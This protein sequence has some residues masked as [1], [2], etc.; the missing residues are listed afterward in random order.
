VERWSQGALQIFGYTEAEVRNESAD[1]IF[2]EEDRK[3]GAPEQEMETAKTTGR[4]ADERWHKRK[5][6]SLFFASGVMRP[7]QSSELTGYVK[8][9]RDT[10]KQQLF[11]E[12]L[13]QLVAER[14]QEL[15]RSNEDLRQFAHV[16][17]HDLKEPIRKIQ[18]FNNRIL[19][20]YG[21]ALPSKAKT[22]AEK[23]GT[24]ADR[25]VSMIEGVLH[26]SKLGN[27]D[28]ALKMVHIGEVIQQ[29]ITD[30]EILIQQKGARIEG[31]GLPVVI[32]SPTLL[33]QL[34]YNLVLNA[35]KFAKKD[36]APQ[37][38]IS[39][40]E[41][42]LEGKSFNRILVADNGIGFEP[43]F[44]QEIFK[45]FT[46][47]H[48]AEDYEGTG[49]GLALC[50]KIVERHGGTIAASSEPEKGATFIILLP[51]SSNHS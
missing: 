17:S 12:E 28:Q 42:I 25:M 35:L 39:S 11:T 24:S 4:A 21:D 33:Y 7:I 37:I 1:I 49:L 43:E 47:L 38:V 8:I 5:D 34:F 40:S 20:E 26:Y 15:Q 22:Y 30:L 27:T 29:V 41:T 13:H 45:T 50:K 36:Q 48:P 9:L 18:T 23:I 19:E 44:E 2:T 31:A 32:G 6:G 10:T 3:A 16:A 51:S 46:R 14:T